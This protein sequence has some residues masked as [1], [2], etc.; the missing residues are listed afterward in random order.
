MLRITNSMMISRAMRNQSNNLRN[1][2]KWNN[3]LNAMTHLHKPSDD[4]VKV[5]RT[6]RLQSEITLSTQY[7]DNLDSAKSWLETT[8][9]SLSE[10]NKVMQRIREITVQG[11]NGVLKE[12]DKSKISQEIGQLRDH[13]INV[14]NQTYTGRHIFSGYRS[15]LAFTNSDG[16][17][18]ENA[19]TL[20][21]SYQS[22][23]YKVGVSQNLQVNYTGDRIFGS[24]YSEATI[25]G[26][27]LEF[28]N[29]PATNPE[30]TTQF[31]FEIKLDI[32]K[33]KLDPATGKPVLDGS[34]NPILE[35]AK[36]ITINSDPTKEYKNGD[37]DSVVNDLNAQIKAYIP[38][39][40][41][42]KVKFVVDKDRIAIVSRDY[43][44]ETTVVEINAAGVP[45][46]KLGKSGL[47]N[48]P[49]VEATQPLKPMFE[50]LTKLQGLLEAGDSENISKMLSDVDAHLQ[51]ILQVSGEIGAKI[52]M[53]DIMQTRMD[54]T[55]IST[56]DLLSKTRDTN[57][58]EAIMNLSIAEAVYKSSLAVSARIIQPT[59][60][61]FLR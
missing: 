45:T 61:D 23:E 36:T 43:D 52:N 27:R 22:M 25:T 17:Y 4:P 37:I 49:N 59:L 48:K 12:D 29:D 41:E 31:D 8:E 3:D 7:S 16:T 32:Q 55:L 30:L 44:I 1:M 20:G 51:N 60:V 57:M 18:N 53:V 6:L 35:D 46:D 42:D 34:G 2:D 56:K 9:S 15:D 39:G 21:V 10:V 47:E 24:P 58:G 19:N 38:A 14:S 26:K 50:M 40:Y 33:K 13:L 28:A 11:A 5:G 54:E